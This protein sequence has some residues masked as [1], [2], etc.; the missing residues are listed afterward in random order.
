MS[1]LAEGHLGR[2]P[3][4]KPASAILPVAEDNLISWAQEPLPQH[5]V[6]RFVEL[7]IGF[8]RGH[9]AFVLR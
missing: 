8:E 5:V 9:E 6:V 2:L 7:D 4:A 3:T 1:D